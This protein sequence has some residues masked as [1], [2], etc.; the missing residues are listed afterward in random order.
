MVAR[1]LEERIDDRAFCDDREMAQA[2]VLSGWQILQPREGNRK[3]ECLGN[4][5]N[6]YLH[7]VLDRG[8]KRWSCRAVR[9][10][11]ST[12]YGT[13]GYGV[14]AP[15]DA[16]RF[17]ASKGT[18]AEIRTGTVRGKIGK[19]YQVSPQDGKA[20]VSGLR[21]R[22]GKAK[23]GSHTK[24]RTSRR[25]SKSLQRSPSG[26]R[27]RH[28]KKRKVAKLSQKLMYTTIMAYRTTTRASRISSTMRADTLKWL[29]RRSQKGVTPEKG[30]EELLIAI[31]YRNHGSQTECEPG[32]WHDNADA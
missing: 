22:W 3:V 31:R 25:I 9:P 27:N 29:N 24:R 23:R 30:F 17:Y 13:T 21:V 5:A 15:E 16:E 7:Y 1:M 19:D 14:R 6:V 4:T 28:L 11:V 26:A 18:A 10:G 2:G 8:L 20:R 12:A 32:P